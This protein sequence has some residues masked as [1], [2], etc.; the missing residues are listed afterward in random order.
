MNLGMSQEEL[1]LRCGL[2]RSYTGELERGEGNPSLTSLLRI[3]R[4][5][6]VPVS[7]L[8][9]QVEAGRGAP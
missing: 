4:G 3:A 6:G 5:L 1:A 7:A 9:A 8:V 2:D